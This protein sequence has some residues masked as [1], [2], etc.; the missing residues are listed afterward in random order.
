[1]FFEV[2]DTD[3]PAEKVWLLN[4]YF[5]RCSRSLQNMQASYLADFNTRWTHDYEKLQYRDRVFYG[6]SH[7]LQYLSRILGGADRHNLL[8]TPSSWFRWHFQFYNVK[9]KT[10]KADVF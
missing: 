4:I 9:K 3:C 2:Y 7:G 5:A 10:D 1:M 8:P 6:W